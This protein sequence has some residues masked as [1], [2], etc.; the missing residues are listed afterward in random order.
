MPDWLAAVIFGLVEGLTKFILVSSNGHLVPNRVQFPATC[1]RMVES[2]GQI[3]R[4]LLRGSSLIA[5][6]LI[7]F[8]GECAATFELLRQKSFTTRILH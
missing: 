2:F 3:P 8:E 7:G 1:R 4:S 5:S 6:H